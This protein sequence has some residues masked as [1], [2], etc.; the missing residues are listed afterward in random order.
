MSVFC[1]IRCRAQLLFG[2]AN[3]V[4]LSWNP[5]TKCSFELNYEKRLSTTKKRCS[6][7]NW[8]TMHRSI[9]DEL[10]LSITITDCTSWLCTVQSIAFIYFI[11]K[12]KRKLAITIVVAMRDETL[13]W[14]TKRKSECDFVDPNNKYKSSVLRDKLALVFFFFFAHYM[15]PW[16]FDASL[17]V[18]FCGQLNV[19]KLMWCYKLISRIPSYRWRYKR[20]TT[21]RTWTITIWHIS[22]N[23]TF[24]SRLPFGVVLCVHVA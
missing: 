9:V 22:F 5:T 19:F 7:H 15:Q 23:V 16:Y 14:Q 12:W 2:A 6:F 20:T 1:L 24:T 8:C 18:D 11:A 17:A 3:E 21:S 13:L 4:V 10:R